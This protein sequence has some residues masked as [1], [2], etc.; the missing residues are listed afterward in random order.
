[1]IDISILENSLNETISY[2]EYFHAFGYSD[3]DIVYFRTFDDKSR[4]TYGTNYERPLS[5]IND[6]LQR[7]HTVND[8]GRGVFYIV[9]GGGQKD[10]NVKTAR[11]QFV[12][13]DDFSFVQQIDIINDFELEPSIIVKTKKSLHCYWLLEE[14]EI[15]AFRPIQQKL[16]AY[17]G[18]D[19]VI[20]NESR[21]MRL[22]GF[23]HHKTEQPARVTLI[24]FDP[25]LKYTQAEI[26]DALPE[27]LTQQ[28]PNRED[29]E[30][31]SYKKEFVP[32][33]QRHKYVVSKIG[34]ILGKLKD[35]ADDTAILA[36]I[37]TDLLSKC[38]APE[39]ITK[40][41][42]AFRKKYL[43]TIQT[44]RAKQKA[45]TD[46]PEYYSKALKAWSAENIGEIF[47]PE[48]YSWQ[49]VREAYERAQKKNDYTENL[50]TPAKSDPVER[51]R[52]D[53]KDTRQGLTPVEDKT[54]QSAAESA[55]EA[56]TENEALPG[57]LTYEVAV[58]HFK[59]ANTNYL[60]MRNFSKFSELAKIGV[61]DSVVLAADTGGG[62]SSLALNFINDL[63]DEYPIMYFNLEM[64]NITVL[65]RLVSIRT[66]IELDRIE[67]YQNDEHTAEVV[68]SALK[69]MTARKPLQI[70]S[71]V[72]DLQAIEKEIMRAATGRKE[73]TIVIIDHSL[74]VRTA[75]N[76]SRY[77]RFTEISENLRRIAKLNN[78]VLFV[79]LQQS[80]EGKKDEN[81][82]PKN[83]SL[84]ES[85]SWE[86]DATHIVF[87]W[88]DPTACRKKL[89]MTKHRAG[90][91]GDVTLDYY[92]HT[93]IYK[94]APGAVDPTDAP[95][96]RQ[97][98]GRQSKRDKE[99][100][101]LREAYEKAITI[102]GGE[103]TLYDIAEAA[104]ETTATIKRR[105]KEYGGYTIDGEEV[106]AAG[107]DTTIS[108]AEFV[109][110][111]L[112]E[113]EQLTTADEIT[114]RL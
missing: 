3:N 22:Y 104:G 14:S 34:E 88:Y 53:E 81:E 31:K 9:N 71:D 106:N 105:I 98:K 87:L 5:K 30:S 19:P 46:D 27:D 28:E 113:E 50:R 56:H 75:G 52:S 66:G 4:D 69:A 59:E 45:E 108:K 44:F 49:E 51:H 78:I 36:L 57:L 61:H 39:D 12:D 13:F 112:S 35:S 90:E 29:S 107:T 76:N 37:E 18:S 68:N 96:N 67:G 33:G 85:G 16:N 60:Q 20:Q 83:W 10:E 7:L 24:K 47:D 55:T 38:E 95:R 26:L 99:R 94:E 15:T 77:E 41:I 32:K 11:A 82:R 21:V 79:L 70:I 42:N 1:M 62:K 6:M 89:I 23:D 54:P 25:E 100:E 101:K 92:R 111:T 102:T 2:T 97:P 43:K 103:P 64:D 91:A 72:Y 86:N 74:L 73:P 17:F 80:R 65:R 8:S 84:K 109:R 48:R 58:K 40:D 114:I 63:N 110:L 93:Q